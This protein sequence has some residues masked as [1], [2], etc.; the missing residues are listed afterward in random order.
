VT[1]PA[2][3]LARVEELLHAA[4]TLADPT[5]AAS[6][7]L[8][9]RLQQTTGLSRPSIDFA[10]EHCLEQRPS[11]DDLTMLL[12]RTPLATRALVLLSA[13]VF[14]APLRAI[15]LARAASDVVLVRAS[16]RDPALAEALLELV[17]HA[18]RLV[19]RLQ[20]EPGDH[21]WAYGAD[22]TLAQVRATLPSGAAFHGHGFGFGAVVVD[23]DAGAGDEERDARAIALD[24]VL[25]DQ[26]GCLSPRLVLVQGAAGAAARLVQALAHELQRLHL[27]LP[28][29]LEAPEALAERRRFLD[30]A[31]YAFDVALAGPSFVSLSHDARLVVPPS[32]RNL[33]VACVTDAAASLTPFRPQLTC[34]AVRGPVDLRHRLQWALPGARCC[35]LGQMQRPPLDGPVD[36][37]AY[38]TASAA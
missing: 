24:T 38:L 33:H 15:A 20:P 7:R 37:R 31:T 28:A 13:N 8:R 29:A 27:A 34:V 30:A 36:L 6:Q 32:G 21:L 16:R 14:V 10:L 3:R 23:Y 5:A 11:A 1:E 17:P 22:A 25:F 4:R 26:Q 19:S 2:T 35:E 18:F 9:Q 12:A